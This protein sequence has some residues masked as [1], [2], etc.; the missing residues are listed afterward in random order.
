[1]STVLLFPA[2]APAPPP[3]NPLADEIALALYFDQHCVVQRKKDE[4]IKNQRRLNVRLLAHAKK[5][6]YEILP[7]DYERWMLSVLQAKPLKYKT[8]R[9]YQSAISVFYSYLQD[10]TEFQNLVVATTGHRLVNPINSRNR[11]THRSEDETEGDA[12]WS[13]S[14]EEMDLLFTTITDEI[15]RSIDRPRA[16]RAHQRNKAIIGLEYYTGTRISE[17][18]ALNTDNFAQVKATSKYLGRFSAIRVQGKAS[19][20]SPKK[21]AETP[22]V[23]AAFKPLMQW[24]LKDIRKKFKP[25]ASEKALF[26]NESGRRLTRWSVMA[27]MRNYLTIAGLY[28]P[29]KGSHALR[30]ACLTHVADRADMALAQYVGRHVFQ[31]TTQIYTRL[32][33]QVLQNRLNAIVSDSVASAHAAVRR[34]ARNRA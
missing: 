9:Y 25:D 18:V 6:F 11:I 30:R 14:H 29:G 20:C 31:A 22:A 28:V 5:P 16:L 1:M 19:R 32:P 33:P 23:H 8:Q 3:P 13:L 7:A 17:V 10:D 34:S 26:L 2:N 21:A 15:E 27:A 12:A 4:T 24:Y